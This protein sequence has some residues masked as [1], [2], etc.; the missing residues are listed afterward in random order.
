MEQD[1]ERTEMP[2]VYLFWAA[3]AFLSLNILCMVYAIVKKYRRIQFD[4]RMQVRR[5]RRKHQELE[6]KEL[7]TVVR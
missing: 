1:E 2:L 5:L 6:L 4:L 3:I 7:N